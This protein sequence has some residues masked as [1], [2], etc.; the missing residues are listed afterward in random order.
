MLDL[1]ARFEQQ[2]RAADASTGERFARARRAVT[3]VEA[4]AVTGIAAA[5]Q[6]S[7]STY[8]LQAQPSANAS[9]STLT[10]WYADAGNRDQVLWALNL[11]PVGALS[12]LWFIAVV[13]KR[14]GDRED[15]FF[16]TVFLGTGL[17]LA[18]FA[19]AAASAAAAPVLVVEYGDQ[20]TP[21]HDVISLAHSLWFGLYV[22]CASR[23]AAVF[24]FVASTMGMRLGALPR[25]LGLLGYAMSIVL[26]ITGAFSGPLAELFPIWLVIVSLTLLVTAREDVTSLYPSSSNAAG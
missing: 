11:A 10:S 5:I 9:S 24:M 14:L 6:I 12:F 25:W 8:L 20:A 2:A 23:F 22:I 16:S 13:R 1:D 4:A 3:S 26:F 21:S 19:V 15:Q 17:A 7:L 18:F